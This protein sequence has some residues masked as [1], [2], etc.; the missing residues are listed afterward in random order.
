MVMALTATILLL[1]AC[2]SKSQEQVVRDLQSKLT[3]VENYKTSADMTLTNGERKSMYHVDVWKNEKDFYRIHLKPSDHQHSQ[4]IIRNKEGV[5]L[6]SPSMNKSYRFQSDW[7][8]NGS[9]AYLFE[10]LVADVVQDKTAVF[11]QTKK[12]YVF[13]TKT[14]YANKQFLAKQTITFDKKT[15]FPTSVSILDE[16]DKEVMKVKF[17]KT[18]FN[19]TFAKSDFEVKKNLSGAKLEQPTMASKEQKDSSFTVLYPTAKLK[20]VS[21]AEEK[22]VS[23]ENGKRSILVYDGDKSYT[24]IQEKN[25]VLP[26]ADMDP[27]VPASGEL[28]DLGYSFGELDNK[29]I[30]WMVDG[31]DY[32]LASNDLSKEELL[33]VARSVQGNIVK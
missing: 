12:Q 4:M 15:L 20:G 8:G 19:P 6:L 33:D 14:R 28:V 23:T 27:V 17:M 9:Q 25:E 30:T 7:P 26:T 18:Q 24:L 1:A 31:V 21:L 5:F 16:S 3:E 11:K 22:T 10:A 2:G 13:E 32:W 29:S